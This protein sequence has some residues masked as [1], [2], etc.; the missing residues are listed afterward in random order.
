V[1][2]ELKF[3]GELLTEH[4]ATEQHERPQKSPP[5][6]AWPPPPCPTL[7]PLRPLRALAPGCRGPRAL[8]AP[9]WG[10]APDARADCPP[11]THS[12][13]PYDTL[14]YCPTSCA[15]CP[16]RLQLPSDS[17]LFYIEGGFYTSGP[18][19]LFRV[20]VRV[21]VRLGLGSGLG[22][23]L[24][25]GFYTGGPVGLSTMPVSQSAVTS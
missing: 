7:P 8:Q 22:V 16:P 23:Y 17:A 3:Q 21:R 15:D 11:H 19:G 6:W 1:S 5:T 24:E 25:G 13:E 12:R 10:P 2:A 14:L 4:G 18:V 20:R 9:R